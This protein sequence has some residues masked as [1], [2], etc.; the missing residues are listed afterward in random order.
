MARHN[1]HGREPGNFKICAFAG[2][3]DRT[4]QDM[5]DNLFIPFGHQRYKLRSA[6]SQVVNKICFGLGIKSSGIYPPDFCD[7]F[8]CLRSNMYFHFLC[9]YF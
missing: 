4:K 2:K 6:F 1:G 7:V 8:F 5:A 9:V 3:R